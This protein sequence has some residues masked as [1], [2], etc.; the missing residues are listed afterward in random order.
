MTRN[1]DDVKAGVAATQQQIAEACAQVTQGRQ[2]EVEAR[3]EHLRY[4]YWQERGRA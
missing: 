2:A 1:P 3:M 4:S